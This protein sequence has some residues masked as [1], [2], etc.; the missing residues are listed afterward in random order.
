M[1]SPERGNQFSHFVFTPLQTGF[2]IRFHILADR[3]IQR[4]DLLASDLHD[5]PAAVVREAQ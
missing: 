2:L 1:R 4:D 3:R 5:S